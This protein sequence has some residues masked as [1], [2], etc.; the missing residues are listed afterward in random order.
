MKPTC[1]DAASS[2]ATVHAREKA[3]TRNGS[4][5]SG[6]DFLSDCLSYE[7]HSDTDEEVWRKMVESG[8]RERNPYVEGDEG[9]A[10]THLESSESVKCE[11][12]HSLGEGE[13]S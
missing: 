2:Q 7:A 11:P 5:H 6:Y 13:T 9:K 1:E 10:R 3:Y 8:Y 4:D 12:T